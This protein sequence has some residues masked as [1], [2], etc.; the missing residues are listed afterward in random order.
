MTLAALATAWA[1]HLMAALSPGPAV[2]LCARLAAT[3][4]MRVGVFYAM[5]VG[6]GGCVWALAALLGMSVLFDHA[7]GVLWAFKIAGGAFL[8]WLGWKMWR[9]A[10]EPLPDIASV[11]ETR[12]ALS[13]V[14]LGVLTQLANPK[15]A[16]FFGAVFVSTVPHQPGAALTLGL[17]AMVFV[18]ETLAISGFARLFSTG[19]MRSAYARAKT[20]V[21]RSFGGILA[22]LGIKIA[23]T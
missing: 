18:N 14:R 16:V 21:D 5:G 6:I 22:L 13:A 4:G 1:I 10:P 20:T 9:H 23:A 11:P 2:L 7:P 8:V 15:T 3:E 17:L 12:S 19:M